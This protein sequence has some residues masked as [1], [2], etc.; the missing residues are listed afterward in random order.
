MLVHQGK[1]ARVEARS[2]R[3]ADIAANKR[4]RSNLR[5][6]AFAANFVWEKGNKE[7]K[8]IIR[9]GNTGAL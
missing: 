6:V 3:V 2:V 1:K 7:G 9:S 5:F 4:G 8:D